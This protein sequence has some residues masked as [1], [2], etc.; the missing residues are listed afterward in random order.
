MSSVK[1]KGRQKGAAQT[2]PSSID[3]RAPRRPS[4]PAPEKLPP[5]GAPASTGSR[6]N[7]ILIVLSL[8]IAAVIA[9]SNL[10][11]NAFVYFDDNLYI[12]ANAHVKSGLS[13]E[14]VK[15]AFDFEEKQDV[16]WQPLTWLALM[17]IH[18]LFGLNSA[19]F[20]LASL[21]IHILNSL[22]LF[23]ILKRMTGSIWPSAFVAMLFAL[24]PLNVESV[25]W[26]AEL[27]TISS[28]LFGLLTIY[29]YVSYTGDRDVKRYAAALICFCV[30]LMFKPSLV[31][32]PFVLL[33]LDWWPL[34]RVGA[35]KAAGAA[36]SHIKALVVEKVPFL[37]L[38]VASVTIA[39][40]SLK[41]YD[42]IAGASLPGLAYRLEN[43]VV[44]Y[45]LYISKMILP[46]GLAVFYPNPPAYALWKPAGAVML[47]LAV[48]FL[49]MKGARKRPYLLVGWLW[50][51][52][53]LFPMTGLVR[54]GLWP[55]IANRFTY[56]PMI[57][58]FIIIAWGCA[59][60]GQRLHI[61]KTVLCCLAGIVIAAMMLASRHYVSYW[62]NGGSLFG[63]AI[64]VTENNADAY[65]GLGNFYYL[66]KDYRK[67]FQY[68]GDALKIDPEKDTVLAKTGLIYFKTGNDRE[69]YQYYE[70]ALKINPGHAGAHIHMGVLY[71]KL[72]QYPEAI[73][74]YKAAL[75]IRPENIDA[76]MKLGI[77]YSE[78][79]KHDEAIEEFSTIVRRSPHDGS[80]LGNL[81]RALA[82]KGETQEALARYEEALR[83]D[84]DNIDVHYN[85]G[86][87]FAGLQQ[88][89]QAAAQFEEVLKIEPNHLDAL[90]N[91][92]SILGMLGK[93][94]PAIQHL[95]KAVEI[96]PEN[97]LAKKNLKAI[98]EAAAAPK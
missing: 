87:L 48:S 35:S 54:S 98:T 2:A 25:A 19:A 33:L 38:S 53:V 60:I 9:Y 92:G 93:F 12:T 61:Q 74:E 21:F 91:L 82:R 62:E 40:I 23:F 75:A 15:W 81:G 6:N 16:Y 27:K 7:I 78:M 67:A 34:G 85:L 65:E 5:A 22:L 39:V 11:R 43:A 41:H 94:D 95:K 90:I 71:A 86:L 80:A 10:Y 64:D 42:N 57:G 31:T 73:A 50:Y 56:V 79:G 17:G 55:E 14:G 13:L 51:L 69:A 47:L 68:Y 32:L 88:Y 59:E 46:I 63:Y 96:S 49:V 29:S 72:G 58:L 44:S 45:A 26:A 1:K 97:E 30:S 18:Q 70:R 83:I 37:L 4:G 20:H 28:T 24:H 36:I 89:G 66:Q 77:A 8:I 84:P 3:R 52:G 76:R